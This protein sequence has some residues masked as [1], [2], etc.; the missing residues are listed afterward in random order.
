MQMN[1]RRTAMLASKVTSFFIW[2]W[3]ES[4]A[5][6]GR[7]CVSERR[8]EVEANAVREHLPAPWQELLHSFRQGVGSEAN[9]VREHFPPPTR[10]T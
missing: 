3:T 5:G 4:P 1:K 6:S 8:M 2:C 7:A 9:K 10:E